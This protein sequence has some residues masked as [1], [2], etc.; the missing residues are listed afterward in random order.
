[1]H[2]SPLI[3]PPSPARFV[4][5]P[6]RQPAAPAARADGDGGADAG[7][8]RTVL[9]HLQLGVVAVGPDG[10]VQ[11]A[12]RAARVLGARHPELQLDA[13]QRPAGAPLADG[14]VQAIAAARAGRWT[15]VTLGGGAGEEPLAIAVVPL[16][17]GGGD[18]GP[19]LLL[20]SPPRGA[21]ALA[22]Q[23][24]ARAAGLTAA[25]SRVLRALADGQPPSRIA[26]QH[27]VA[28]STVRSQVG[29][30]R[31]KT[32]ARSITDL[33]RAVGRLPPVMPAAGTV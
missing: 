19:V 17:S 13:R 33:T 5:G 20:F 1:M 7:L 8:L 23:L 12:N 21:D 28:V 27:D 26:R 18:E 2:A 30:I 29:S 6:L 22:M 4:P 31:A 32:G 3:L 10:R 16:G 14:L 9:D 11:H 24:F 25:E 15:L